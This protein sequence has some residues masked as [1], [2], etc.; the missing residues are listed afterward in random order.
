MIHIVNNMDFRDITGKEPPPTPISAKLYTE[1]G[2]PWFEL[3]D[4]KKIEH[5]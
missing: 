4:E 5:F 2:Y 3:L 1:Y